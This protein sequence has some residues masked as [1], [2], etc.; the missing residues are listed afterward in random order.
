MTS[1]TAA[2]L[3]QNLMAFAKESPVSYAADS[4]PHGTRRSHSTMNRLLPPVV[5]SSALILAACASTPEPESAP[6][7]AAEFLQQPAQEN[8]IGSGDA[9]ETVGLD[10]LLTLD[11]DEEPTDRDG[12]REGATLGRNTSVT[13][14]IDPTVDPRLAQ[15]LVAV[16]LDYPITVAEQWDAL[17]ATIGDCAAL[18][19]SSECLAALR[20]ET[21][22]HGLLVIE[23]AGEA[24]LRLRHYELRMGHAGRI[25]N[26]ALP[27]A[28]GTVPRASLDQLADNML[29]EI[30]DRARLLPWS[31]GIAGSQNGLWRIN[32]RESDGLSPGDSLIAL[33]G[34]RTLRNVLGE[35]VSWMPGTAVA[36]LVIEGYGDD[37]FALVRLD[38][39]SS[40]RS[41]DL[42]VPAP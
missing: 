36:R 28:N 39:G 31:A 16:S 20:D 14:L 29:L 4:D 9:I 37:G 34:D 1:D 42:L 32:V 6:V 40:P 33:R 10:D 38:Q 5:L 41:S 21:P 23:D 24:R 17:P 30:T 35:P 19:L 13:L 3:H 2:A 12:D 7:T 11:A 27:I 25:R 8:L 15:R 26:V 22:S 18:D